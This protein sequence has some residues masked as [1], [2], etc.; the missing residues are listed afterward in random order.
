MTINDQDMEFISIEEIL[1]ESDLVTED[2]NKDILEEF[3]DIYKKFEEKYNEE[4]STEQI[5]TDALLSDDK[6]EGMSQLLAMVDKAIPVE[7]GNKILPSKEI[8]LEEV[9]L[10]P[11]E[12]SEALKIATLI[13][14]ELNSKQGILHPIKEI[15]K[16]NLPP[17]EEEIKH[18]VVDDIGLRASISSSDSLNSILDKFKL[19]PKDISLEVDRIAQKLTDGKPK[20]KINENK[21]NSVKLLV[22]A[23]IKVELGLSERECFMTIDDIELV[24]LSKYISEVTIREIDRRYTVNA[25]NLLKSD[26]PVEISTEL[27]T[28]QFEEL[29]RHETVR[30][31]ILL[32]KNKDKELGIELINSESGNYN[33]DNEQDTSLNDDFAILKPETYKQDE[34]KEDIDIVIDSGNYKLNIELPKLNLGETV[35]QEQPNIPEENQIN[36]N[37][38]RDKEESYE[39]QIPT[40]LLNNE[41][42]ISIASTESIHNILDKLS[43][44]SSR[45]REVDVQEGEPKGSHQSLDDFLQAPIELKLDKVKHKELH[46]HNEEGKSIKVPVINDYTMNMALGRNANSIDMDVEISLGLENLQAVPVDKEIVKEELDLK[47]S[48]RRTMVDSIISQPIHD[49]SGIQE[50]KIPKS[51]PQFGN[52]INDKTAIRKYFQKVDDNVAD[53]F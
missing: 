21:I 46:Y 19:K 25:E 23:E 33:T 9:V 18:G 14:M 24:E 32:S 5:I 4:H 47:S 16:S 48:V 7:F 50:N 31:E 44:E 40:D 38:F 43:N 10:S 51:K 1:Q 8:K 3:S 15:Q 12:K 45:K 22:G 39:I 28:D 36:L 49:D 2:T 20:L 41:L 37:Q 53:I 29:I 6:E 11:E 34:Y 27:F 52:M 13:V 42:N 30:R 35:K 17:I 26:E